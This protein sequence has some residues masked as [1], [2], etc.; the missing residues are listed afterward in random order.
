MKTGVRIHD[1]I[2]QVIAVSL[3]SILEEVKSG[4]RLHWG[5]TLFHGS[6]DLGSHRSIPAFEES[7]NQSQNG[8][9]LS[10]TELNQLAD[11]L[12]EI[13]D[14][15]LIGCTA[16]EHLHRYPSVREMGRSCETFIQLVDSNFWQVLSNDSQLIVRL[17][18]K[19]RQVE[20][21]SIEDLPG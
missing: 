6:G 13:E 3:A 4:D 1:K 8:V 20:D 12:T 14:I 10:W 21:C 17:T 5:I 2:N 11:K 9:G 15:T 18:K 19:Y 7:C 16:K